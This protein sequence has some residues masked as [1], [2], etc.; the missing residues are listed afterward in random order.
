VSAREARRAARREAGGSNAPLVFG[1]ILVIIGLVAFI[2]QVF[3]QIDFDLIWPIGL[4]LLGGALVVGARR[5]GS[6]S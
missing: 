4:I 3:P 1:A 6:P 5:R 2:G